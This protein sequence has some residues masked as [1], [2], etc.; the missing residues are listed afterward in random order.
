M[1]TYGTYKTDTDK[2]KIGVV[3]DLGSAGKFTIARAGGANKEFTKKVALASKPYRLQIQAAT[4]D[5]ALTD[6]ILVNAF[7]DTVLKGWEGV[8]DENEQPIPYNRDSAIKL[9]TDLPDLFQEL[10]RAASD[11]ST[12]RAV[13]LEGDSKN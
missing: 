10:T 3:V 11:A 5:S 7:V 4:V 9:F 2:E 12:F 6:R 13:A 8:T 1:S